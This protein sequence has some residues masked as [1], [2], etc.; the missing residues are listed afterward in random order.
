MRE[1]P[2][3]HPKA[4]GKEESLPE[5]REIIPGIWK[6][7]LPIPFPLK[8]VNVY[9][10]IGKGGWALLDAG[11]G[12]PLARTA[13]EAGLVT[14]G[15]KIENL[16]MIILSHNHPDH[17][18]LS[19]ELQEQSGAPVY[20]HRITK[21]SLQTMWSDKRL[22]GF[23]RANRFLEQNGMPTQDY[24][25]VQANSADMKKILRVPEDKYITAVE[26]G[27]DLDI[28]GKH[29]QV[30]W[31]P[32]HADGHICLFR[33][34]DGLFIAADHVLPGITPNIGIF[35]NDERLN[36]LADYLESLKKVS[37]LPATLVLPG[38]REPFTDLARRTKEIIE[39][40]HERENLIK[41][42][43]DQEPQHAY[44]L[45]GQVFGARLKSTEA[46]R[47]GVAEILSHL[48]HLRIAGKVEKKQDQ[49]GHILY[50]NVG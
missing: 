41:Q 39:H 42:L 9:A 19:G 29:Y 13:F 16:R 20:T 32:G 21:E 18:G 2:P 35:S 27:Q 24:W 49:N 31:T 23:A 34:S 1:V 22:D 36:P 3:A 4:K 10:L 40:H 30:I 46:T 44:Q 25:G 26:D 14:A 37:T 28:L 7:T 5:T 6:I 15:L 12:I 38:H 45:A 17:I 50:A 33:P 11:I 43:V 47:M 8:T 48:E